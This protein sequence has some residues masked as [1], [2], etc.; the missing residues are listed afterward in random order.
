MPPIHGLNR[1]RSAFHIP[2]RLLGL[3]GPKKL[4]DAYC[5]NTFE[6]GVWLVKRVPA[7]QGPSKIVGAR[8]HNTMAIGVYKI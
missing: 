5:F 1:S 6:G 2:T 4:T 8:W 3:V 7:L